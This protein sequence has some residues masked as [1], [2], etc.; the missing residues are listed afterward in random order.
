[1]EIRPVDPGL[2]LVLTWSC[3]STI[4][5]AQR[6]RVLSVDLH[7]TNYKTILIRVFI[8]LEMTYLKYGETCLES[9]LCL[10]DGGECIAGVCAC[11]QNYL[12]YTYRSPYEGCV[13]EDLKAFNDTYDVDKECHSII[14]G[15]IYA[16]PFYIYLLEVRDKLSIF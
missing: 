6:A 15:M 2:N 10:Y 7:Y 11:R 3:V 9:N 14:P 1:M 16:K 8:Y 4:I 5:H 12:N 13:H